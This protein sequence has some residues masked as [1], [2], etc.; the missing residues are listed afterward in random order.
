MVR[1]YEADAT[2]VPSGEKATTRTGISMALE[3][4]CG[5]A[6]RCVLE[7]NGP[8][9]RDRRDRRAVWRKGDGVDGVIM[10]LETGS[11]AFQPSATIPASPVSNN[12]T[13]E[14]SRNGTRFLIVDHTANQRHGS[15][16]SD[17][18]LH[19]RERR[20]CENGSM[21]RYWRCGHCTIQKTLKV[22]ETG[23]V[24]AEEIDSEVDSNRR[25]YG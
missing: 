14:L 16:A 2:S 8:V 17:I 19:G 10:A 1:S 4:L 5:R 18:W 20:R 6:C 24:K 7:P 13:F 21:D 23:T 15:K 22:P 11:A 12:P 9:V 3:H 25:G